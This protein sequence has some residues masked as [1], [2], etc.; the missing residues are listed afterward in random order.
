VVIHEQSLSITIATI[1]DRSKL[2]EIVQK[3]R[4]RCICRS[5]LK[6][7]WKLSMSV[8]MITNHPM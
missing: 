1:S 5:S 8:R 2:T 4:N 6:T 3:C 7:P